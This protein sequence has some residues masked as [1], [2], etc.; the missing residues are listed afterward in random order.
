MD[1]KLNLPRHFWKPVC[2]SLAVAI[3]FWSNLASAGDLDAVPLP[4]GA[5]ILRTSD[6]SI[7]PGRASGSDIFVPTTGTFE[8][9]Y[10]VEP[11]K[12]LLITIITNEQYRQIATG[13]KLEGAALL[14]A[15][16]S[17]KGKESVQMTRGNY[18]VAFN[19]MSGTGIHLSYRA[20][21]R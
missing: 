7:D 18:F 5:K 6:V 16:V 17:G 15:M 11:G 14:R 21:F 1:M 13:H 2:S 4:E 10:A 8:I 12:K 3:F 20:S 9:D 19:D